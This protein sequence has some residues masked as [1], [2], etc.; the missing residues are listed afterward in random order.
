[1]LRLVTS[2]DGFRLEIRKRHFPIRG[3]LFLIPALIPNTASTT[4]IPAASG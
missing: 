2:W 1:M 3:T 4:C